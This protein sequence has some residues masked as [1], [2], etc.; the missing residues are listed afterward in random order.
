MTPN[1]V[2]LGHCLVLLY[3]SLTPLLVPGTLQEPY[4]A[5]GRQ[6]ADE[7]GAGIVEEGC[8]GAGAL[9]LAGAPPGAPV[10]W[11]S[12]LYRIILMKV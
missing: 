4:D 9:A 6:A 2:G 8:S 5:V 12:V 3:P 11:V 7:E 1:Q 10:T